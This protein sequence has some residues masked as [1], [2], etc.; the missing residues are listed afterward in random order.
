[1]AGRETEAGRAALDKVLGYL[2]FSSGATDPQFLNSLSLLF[3]DV[4]HRTLGQQTWLRLFE[5]LQTELQSLPGTN[6]RP[7]HGEHA[8]QHDHQPGQRCT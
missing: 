2:N 5:W 6:G 8:G 7:L 1:M 4:D 3:E